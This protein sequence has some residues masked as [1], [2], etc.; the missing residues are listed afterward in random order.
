MTE[1]FR[2]LTDAEAEQK[3]EIYKDIRS[4]VMH[5][6]LYNANQVSL[7]EKLGMRV[8]SFLISSS[9]ITS[10]GVTHINHSKNNLLF[11]IHKFCTAMSLIKLFLQKNM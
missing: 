9:F 1:H 10:L 4:E 8:A 7:G 11:N 3:E 6:G 5:S 2:A